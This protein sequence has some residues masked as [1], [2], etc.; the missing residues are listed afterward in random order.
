MRSSVESSPNHLKMMLQDVLKASPKDLR[1]WATMK[2]HPNL[3]GA[4]LEAGMPFDMVTASVGGD[5]ITLQCPKICAAG[6]ERSVLNL[7]V[8]I[9]RFTRDGRSSHA[10]REAQK[11][12]ACNGG[13]PG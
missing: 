3:N 5:H 2:L 8:L 12:A 13:N 1:E 7:G 11:A 4:F 10:G 9:R 6:V